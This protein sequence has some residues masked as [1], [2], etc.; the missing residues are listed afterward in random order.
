M[1]TSSAIITDN[2]L[3]ALTWTDVVAFVFQIGGIVGF[4]LK[5][6]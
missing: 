6:N 5:K 1:K 2:P 3:D 4:S